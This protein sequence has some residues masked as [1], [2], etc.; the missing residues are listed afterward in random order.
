MKAL[1]LSTGDTREVVEFDTKTSYTVIKTAV[2]GWIECIPLPSLGVEMW[3][4]EEGKLANDA[5]LNPVATAMWVDNYGKT[6]VIVG[7][8]IFTGSSDANGNTTGLTDEQIEELLAYS[9]KIIIEPFNVEDFVGFS[10]T[11]F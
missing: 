6:D 9:K 8:V 10:V 7:D 1:K 2:D 3:I 4:N 11:S 5:I